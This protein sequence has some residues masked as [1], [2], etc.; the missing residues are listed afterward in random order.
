[1]SWRGST[2]VSDRILAS[3]PYLLPILDG[4]RFGAF[5]FSQFPL[6]AIILFPLAPLLAIYNA[7]FLGVIT[8]SLIVFFALFILV[9]RN[10]KIPHFI[11]F[12]A[13]QAILLDIVVFLCSLLLELL[14]FFPGASFTTQTLSSTIFLGTLIAVIYAVSQSLLGRYAE[15]PAISEA[16]YTQVR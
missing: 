7:R 10:E 8:V 13:M 15:I 11:R 2:T 12:N 16:V 9:V 5:L 6:L 4:V 1:M 14:S 3:L